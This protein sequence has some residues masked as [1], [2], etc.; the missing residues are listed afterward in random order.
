MG[1]KNQPRSVELYFVND[2]KGEYADV[3]EGYNLMTSGLNALF[4]EPE[5]AKDQ[6][7]QAA[8]NFQGALEE[9]DMNNK[10]ARINAKVGVPLHFNLLECYFATGE[11][12]KATA[13]LSSMNTL[14]LSRTERENK[15]EFESLITDTKARIDANK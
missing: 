5:N 3:T 15:Q 11:I 13:L 6:L 10:K 1:F 2:K 9:A 4:E 14:S 7:N 12:D 8:T